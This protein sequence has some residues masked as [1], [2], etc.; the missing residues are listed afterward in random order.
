M[1]TY[2]YTTVDY[3]SPYRTFMFGINDQAQ[4]VGQYTTSGVNFLYSPYPAYL[5]FGFLTLDQLSYPLGPGLA[6]FARSINDLGQVVGFWN[7]GDGTVTHGFLYNALYNGIQTVTSID[8]PGAFATTAS[9]I[10]DFGEIVGGYYSD[11]NYTGSHGF[12]YEGGA[13]TGFDYPLDPSIG[14]NVSTTLLGVNNIGDILGSYSYVDSTTHKTVEHA[15]IDSNGVF[16]N[17]DF[18]SVATTTVTGLNNLGEVVGY[19]QLTPLGRYYGFVYDQGTYTTLSDPTNA[20]SLLP[21]S[22]NDVGEVTGYY[23][24]SSSGVY[25]GFLATPNT[26]TYMN[27]GG[28]LRDINNNGEILE[29]ESSNFV[30]IDGVKTPLDLLNNNPFGPQT[31]AQALGLN[32][33]GQIVG[34]YYT[35]DDSQIFGEHGFIDSNGALTSI[36]LPTA[37]ASGINNLG[38]VVGWYNSAPY[39]S[40]GFLYSN[41][42]ITADIAYPADLTGI[43]TNGLG[44]STVATQIND[45]GE[46]VGY[47][48]Y[49]LLSGQTVTHGFIDNNGAYSTVDFPGATSTFLTG[50]NNFDEIIGR[51][52][53][54]LGHAYGFVLNSGVFS[55]LDPQYS[56]PRGIDD[57]GDIVGTG[58][59]A[60]PTVTG[61]PVQLTEGNVVAEMAELADEAY[62]NAGQAVARGWHA[63][64]ASELGIAPVASDSSPGSLDY[65][66]S[67]GLY[68]A[69]YVLLTG[70]DAIST[71][72]ADALLLTGLVDGKKTLTIAFRGTDDLSD[73]QD[74]ALFGN[75]YAKYAPLIAGIKNYVNENGIEQVLVTGHSLGAAMVEYFMDEGAISDNMR[76]YT[77]GNPGTHFTPAN[78]NIVNFVHV[79]DPV[80]F[81]GGLVGNSNTG[82]TI[83]VHSVL[84]DEGIPQQLA[85]FAASGFDPAAFAGHRMDIYNID[86]DA[87]VNDAGEQSALNP[88]YASV[89]GSA[90]RTGDFWNPVVDPVQLLPGTS[91]VHEITISPADQFVLGGDGD[92]MM[93][94]DGAVA[95]NGILVIEGGAGRDTLVLPG[96]EAE[97]SWLAHGP[98]F[99]LF[100]DNNFVARLYGIESLLFD[101][102]T[103]NLVRPTLSGTA[104]AS[105]IEEGGA[106][107]LS[108]SITISDFN[109]SNLVGATVAITGGTY[110]S[111]RDVLAA[112]GT[113]SIS[114]SYNSATETLIL[115]GADTLAHYQQVLDTVTFSAGENPTNFGSNPTRTITWVLNDGAGS[116]NLSAPV[117]TTVTITNV[118]DAPTLSGVASSLHVNGSQTVTLSPSVSVSDPDNLKLASSTVKITGGIFAGDG[119]VLAATTTGTGIAAGYNSSTETLTLTGLDTLAH[120]EAVLDSVTF[121]TTSSNPT[122]S[123]SNPTRTVTWTLN[124][125]ATASTAATTT[126][127]ISTSVSHPA[128]DFNGNGVSDVLWRN[129]S[130]EVD[131]W[132]M[133]NGVLAGGAGLASVST[134]WRFAGNGDIDGNGAADVV[135]QNTSNGAVES[136]LINNGQIAGGGGLG[137]ASSV[138]QS[139]GTG[140]FNAAEISDLL[141][142]N[143]TTGEVDTWLMT[144]GRVTGGAAVGSVSSA[145]QVAGIGDINGDGTSDVVWHNTT[146]GAVESWLFNNGQVTGGGGIGFASSAWQALGTGNFNFNGDSIAD[147]LWRNLSTGEVDTWLMN[148]GHVTGGAALGGVSSAW[149]FAGIGDYTGAGT[150]DVLWRNNNTGE[151][152]TWLIT[153]DHLTGGAAISSAST[154]WQP[155]VIHTG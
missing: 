58:F 79:N 48:S 32:D 135:W 52:M 85:D 130:G 37:V 122:N 103:V 4:I 31:Y 128:N 97:W 120:Y 10:N 18:P 54:P 115:T 123:G 114:V 84:T 133:N 91:S 3:L 136:W 86:T 57:A 87:L 15:F 70:S 124:D 38:Q 68:R 17:I 80:P 152:D 151:V 111:D 117:T 72:E 105:F 108:P 8:F 147:I 112:T 16:T 59:V 56:D 21:E 60:T 94:W 73:V 65:L 63:V 28:F 41:G 93:D 146:T 138:W 145:W 55:N 96:P 6:A 98:G 67:G 14:S 20:S 30:Y 142:R 62:R 61:Q 7:N 19:Y 29:S 104:N 106:V 47:Y 95:G 43:P 44:V 11:S 102:A 53:D 51:W 50:V 110:A 107:T 92:D 13:Y 76:G 144:N 119:D 150:S 99:D 139:L 116:L 40:H 35:V 88:F 24:D 39:V 149:Q 66:F 82:P 33:S 140:D 101:D 25:R 83:T 148:N 131:T 81:L 126:I 26:Y 9:S 132:L 12:I 42:A 49:G 153:N 23:V 78:S 141:W 2:A 74:Y 121:D 90:Y 125:G 45:S 155:Q 71:A 137:A 129:V 109:G 64:S 134:A 69:H 46:I 36:D 100:S 22:I 34:T 89:V 77:W 127:A 27:L 113:S 154:A 75:H 1:T 143:T 5:P 118:N